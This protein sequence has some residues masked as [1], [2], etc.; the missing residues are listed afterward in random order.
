VQ[1]IVYYVIF[2]IAGDLAARSALQL[3]APKAD[4][5]L[6]QTISSSACGLPAAEPSEG[7]EHKS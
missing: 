2:M 6:Q 5:A 3:C 7:E 4:P 1:V